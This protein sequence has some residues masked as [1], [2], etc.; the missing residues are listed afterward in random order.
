MASQYDG[1]CHSGWNR[2]RRRTTR[3]TGGRLHDP[4]RQTA[5]GQPRPGSLAKGESSG[6][7]DAMTGKQAAAATVLALSTRDAGCNT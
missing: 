5:T 7:L 4:G 3:G 2:L 1:G 6:Q